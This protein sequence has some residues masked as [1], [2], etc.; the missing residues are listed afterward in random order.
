MNNMLFFCNASASSVHV[1]WPI[2]AVVVG[3]L[4]LVWSAERF[5]AGSASLAKILGMSPLLIGMVIV[6]F[7]TSAPEMCVSVLAAVN[8]SPNIALGNAYGSNIANIALILGL[9]ALISPIFYARSVMKKELPVLFIATL[10]CLPMLLDFELTSLEGILMIAIFIVSMVILSL[11]SKQAKNDE[12]PEHIKA[13]E[14]VK[15]YDSIWI[16]IFW[17]I[18]GLVVLVA[19]SQMLVWGAKDIAFR[20]HVSDLIVGL[21]IVAIGT[22]LPELASSVAAALKKEH[23]IA[24][25]NIIG[26][27]LFNTLMV[28][29]LA[30]S[31]KSFTLEKEVLFRDYSLVLFFTALLFLPLI[32]MAFGSKKPRISRAFGGVLLLL[33]CIYTVYLISLAFVSLNS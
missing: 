6:G 22:S 13:D 23:D 11:K 21:T 24:L 17:L 33:Y 16:S 7:G 26:S 2:L 27:N 29:G 30:S 20:C 12:E 31:V 32:P 19:S 10:L 9:T 25:G 28:V 5:V 3:L 18:V 4:L 8:N 14:E 15:G 1:I